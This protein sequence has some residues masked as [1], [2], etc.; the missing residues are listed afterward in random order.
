M[1]YLYI[2]FPIHSPVAFELVKW[3]YE[4]KN[5]ERVK[6]S[7]LLKLVVKYEKMYKQ[8][9]LGYNEVPR[10]ALN[11]YLRPPKSSLK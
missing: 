4:I 5:K 11:S 8:P 10:P 1:E 7:K 6:A 3:M 2:D 9:K